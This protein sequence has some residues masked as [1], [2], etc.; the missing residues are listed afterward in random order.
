[1]LTLAFSI[2]VQT[3]KWMF[4]NVLL[5][6]AVPKKRKS[7]RK[8]AFCKTKF[9]NAAWHARGKAQN[10]LI[11]KRVLRKQVQ[12]NISRNIQR[13]SG[14]SVRKMKPYRQGFKTWRPS[15]LD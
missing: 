13:M 4:K 9:F 14:T 5:F 6:M 1:M 7:K 8:T 11:Q 2:E 10:A 15:V 12:T 3:L